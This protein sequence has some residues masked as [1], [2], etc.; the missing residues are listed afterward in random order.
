MEDDLKT[1]RE[2]S[3][4]KHTRSQEEWARDVAAV[5]PDTFGALVVV[6][7]TQGRIVGFNRAC[8]RITGYAFDEVQGRHV[9][10]IFFIPEEIEAV[11]AVFG[12]LRAAQFP[13]TSEN[14]WVMKNGQRHRIS[15]SN[16]ALLLDETG[17]VSYVIGTGIDMSARVQAEEA[18]RERDARIHAILDTTVDAII[19]IDEHGTIV[20]FNLA[21][22]RIFGYAT[23]EVLGQNVS[24]LMPSPYREEHDGYLARYLRTGEKR[25]IGIGREAVGRRKDGTT[26]PIDLAVSEVRLGNRR[27]F[28]GIVRDITE[29]KQAEEDRLRL[30][31]IVE[32]S[33]DAIIGKTLDGTIVSWNVGAERLY[34]YTAAEVVGRSITLLIPPDYPNDIP[35]ILAKIQRGERVVHYETVRMAKDGRRLDVS[36]TVSPI[37]IREGTIVGASAIARDITA[38]KRATREMERA[39]RL[40]L[41]GQLTSGIAHEIGTPLNVIVG[42]AELLRQD[43]HEQGL[44]TEALTAI[45][46]HTDRITGLIQRLLTLARAQPQPLA[47]LV[48]HEPLARALRLL[49]TQYRHEAITPIV[50][51][52]ED[53][54]HVWG[55]ADQ[56]EQVF[57]N[58]L[59]NAW[60]AMPDGGTVTIQ[61]HVPDTQHVQI[62][63]RDT[64]I[65]M[66]AVELVR[67]FEPFFSTK[68]EYG[69]GLGLAI[70]QQIIDQH[71]GTIRLDSSPGA[72]TTVTLTLVQADAAEQAC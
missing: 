10:E 46:E 71:R 16:T 1:E 41:V 21:A 39:E 7:D 11:K 72:G 3:G 27:L 67:A 54:P 36:L 4:A 70:C 17:A 12:T 5:L 31:A 66:S 26:F 24:I 2:A 30:A 47:P 61:A 13:H 28:T 25:I 57:L 6:L 42:N 53:L 14:V 50:E 8:E 35:D 22:E 18:L 62:M 19:T 20:S 56:L 29:R 52:P 44:Q 58:V 55:A 64:G 43:L 15:W 40:A 23:A 9:W 45:I 49:D 63:F 34:G 60:H 38:R 65:G 69:T 59:V 68:G 32:S 51:V 33:D 37:K 48:L